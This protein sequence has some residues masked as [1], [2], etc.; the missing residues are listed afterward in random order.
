VA[1]GFFLARGVAIA[2]HKLV[3]PPWRDAGSFEANRKPGH[4]SWSCLGFLGSCCHRI[5]QTRQSAVAWCW[6][7]RT[8][9]KDMPD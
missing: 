9:T 5:T 3:N 6:P 1:F 7:L 2:S 8:E 4:S